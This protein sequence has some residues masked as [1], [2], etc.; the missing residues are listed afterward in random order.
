MTPEEA[1]IRAERARQLLNDELLKSSLAAGTEAAIAAC[2]LV[3]DEKEAWR[4]CMTLKACLDVTR[5][6]AGHIESAKVIEFN[7]K[8]T[9]VDKVL[10]RFTA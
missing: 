8:R 6:L 9:F 3:K 7:S 5:A 1:K 2:S 4:A 10:D